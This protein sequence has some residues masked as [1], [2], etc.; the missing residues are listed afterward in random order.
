MIGL[1]LRVLP[2]WVREPV[3]AVSGTAFAGMLLYVSAR[4]SDLAFAG[5]AAVVLAF[6]A[7]RVYGMVRLLRARRLLKEPAPAGR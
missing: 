4:D 3:L 5:L 2:F 1:I 7:V 6:T